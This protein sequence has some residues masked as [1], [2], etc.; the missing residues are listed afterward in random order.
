MA[1]STAATTKK[2]TIP[3]FIK[4]MGMRIAMIALAVLLFYYLQVNLFGFSHWL[5]A[6]AWASLTHRDCRTYLYG[7]N[8]VRPDLL[9]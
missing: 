3:V 9:V 4:N 5:I 6:Y 7:W 2:I 1:V 8:R